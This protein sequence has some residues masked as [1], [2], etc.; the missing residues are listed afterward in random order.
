MKSKLH[1]IEIAPSSNGGYTV[2]HHFKPAAVHAKGGMFGGMT[3]TAPDAKVHS[4]GA[5]EHGALAKHLME[6]LS[7]R[8]VAGVAGGAAPKGDDEGA[9]D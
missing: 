1:R 5:K 6:A 7:L 4:F 2:T 8:G 3:M 9:E